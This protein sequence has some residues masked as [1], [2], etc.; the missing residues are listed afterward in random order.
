[1][2]ITKTICNSI[3]ENKTR[4]NENY[5]VEKTYRQAIINV[6]EI[7]GKK[8]CSLLI[9]L[10]VFCAYPITIVGRPWG[11]CL[12]YHDLLYAKLTLRQHYKYRLWVHHLPV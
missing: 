11:N 4:H 2:L 1:M 9:Y 7:R 6:S 10:G 3:L 5:W 12:P 8:T